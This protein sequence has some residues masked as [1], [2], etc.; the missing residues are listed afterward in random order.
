MRHFLGLIL[1]SFQTLRNPV[2]FDHKE[3][4]IFMIK[5]YFA[6]FQSKASTTFDKIFFQLSDIIWCLIF[7][8]TDS[9][10][11]S[12]ERFDLTTINVT[13]KLDMRLFERLDLGFP[14]IKDQ[15]F[16]SDLLIAESIQ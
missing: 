11:V 4:I 10:F 13:Q 16:Q 9:I 3:H 15:Q 8:E 12:L 6:L 1:N 2:E 14:A 7:S 5:L